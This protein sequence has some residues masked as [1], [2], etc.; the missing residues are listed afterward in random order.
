M[1]FEW[2]LNFNEVEITNINT[3][4]MIETLGEPILSPI[5]TFKIIYSDYY[6]F[7]LQKCKECLPFRKC[8]I[9]NLCIFDKAFIHWNVYSNNNRFELKNINTIIATIY[10][11]ITYI[12]KNDDNKTYIDY[13][14]DNICTKYYNNTND[15]S[16]L[17]KS[18]INQ[19]P[20]EWST[21]SISFFLIA[22]NQNVITELKDKLNFTIE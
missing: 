17:I 5:D 22:K 9:N 18:F 8:S 21:K 4:K 2:N 10:I 16:N 7:N 19:N 3:N 20:D 13:D 1:N 15:N 11:K 14:W 12:D 6:D